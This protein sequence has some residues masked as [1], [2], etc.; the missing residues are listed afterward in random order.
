MANAA[1]DTLAVSKDLQDAGFETRQAEAIAW[2][3]KQSQGDLATKQDIA[4]L[5]SDIDHLRTELK[6]DIDQLRT[7]LK[8]DNKQ[9]KTEMEANFDK[10]KS[11]ITW[12]KWSMALMIA[13]M[14]GGFSIFGS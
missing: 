5:K 9:L 1:F 11:D 7:E 13:V 10:L 8:S 2:A 6:S 14:I 4:L 3:V 12:I